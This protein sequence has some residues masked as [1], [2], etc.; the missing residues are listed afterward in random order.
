MLVLLKTVSF[1]MATDVFKFK[2]V[3]VKCVSTTNKPEDKSESKCSSV[4]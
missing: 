2:Q 4:C 1:M 3:G